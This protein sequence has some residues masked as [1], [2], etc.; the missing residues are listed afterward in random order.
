M[1][2]PSPALRSQSLHLNRPAG[3]V[4]RAVLPL[5][6]GLLGWLFTGAPERWGNLPFWTDRIGISLGAG[7]YYFYDTQPLGGGSQD[8]H[9]AAPIISLSLTGYFTDRVFYRVMINHIAPST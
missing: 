2:S 7:V 9:G 4:R 3:A 1:K 6:L 5:L 8:E